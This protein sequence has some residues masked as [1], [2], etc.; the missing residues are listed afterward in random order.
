MCK[1]RKMN[2]L[3]SLLRAG[4][5][6]AEWIGRSTFERGYNSFMP[7]R[8][9]LCRKPPMPPHDP[10][11]THH[12]LL[13]NPKRKPRSLPVCGHVDLQASGFLNRGMGRVE[14]KGM[15]CRRLRCERGET[16]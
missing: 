10:Q 1:K 16:M 9:V 7:K 12:R 13:S 4:G 11:S 14:R 15:C 3:R 6:G 8:A 2:R 5:M